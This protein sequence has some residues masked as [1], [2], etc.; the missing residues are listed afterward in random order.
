MRRGRVS[1]AIGGARPLLD[2]GHIYERAGMS[3]DAKKPK[4]LT[5]FQS[6]LLMGTIFIIAAVAIWLPVF[7]S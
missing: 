5:K 6:W 1:L 3:T 7:I 4:Q 2:T